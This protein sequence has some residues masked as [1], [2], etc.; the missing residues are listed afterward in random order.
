MDLQSILNFK[1][2][3]FLFEFL[4]ALTGTLTFKKCR[5]DFSRY[6][7]YFLCSVFFIELIGHYTSYLE[8]GYFKFLENTSF[9]KN[10]WLYN[11]YIIINFLFY[12]LFFSN[13]VRS[14]LVQTIFKYVGVFYV[15]SSIINL[16]LID[17]YYD[18]ISAYSFIVGALLLLLSVFYYFYEVLQTDDVLN[19]RSS[20]PFYIAM[21]AMVF[22]LSVTP[23]FIYSRYF[24]SID[25]PFFVKIYLITL[26]LANIFMYTCYIIAFIV[27]LKKNRSY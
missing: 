19:I 3:V 12:F 4:A 2:I 27:C 26:T 8:S 5:D 13:H 1:E 20:F 7:V 11:P 10:Y 25:N 23:L 21:G 16:F 15:I 9:K 22:H 18:G 6:F 24:I 14:K 17:Y